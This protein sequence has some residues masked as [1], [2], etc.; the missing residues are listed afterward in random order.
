[1]TRQG[2][3]KTAGTSVTEMSKHYSQ[4]RKYDPDL[5]F[6]PQNWIYELQ[7]VLMIT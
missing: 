6:I 3:H 5:Y 2:K 4:V 1:M 7:K